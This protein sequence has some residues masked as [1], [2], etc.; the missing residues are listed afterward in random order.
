M[1]CYY[2]LEAWRSKDGGIT[3]ELA[4]ANPD[5]PVML[6]CGGCIGC[7]LDKSNEW[8]LRCVHEAQF[9]SDSCFV[10][11]T[12]D[13]D[14]LPHNES[15]I[16]AHICTFMKSLK[17]KL[18]REKKIKIRY[19]GGGEYGTNQQGVLNPYTGKVQL[20]RPHYHAIIFGWN[21]DDKVP[22]K[23]ESKKNCEGY[24]TYTSET[25][26]KVWNKGH[27]VLGDLTFKSARY[28]AGYI[29]KKVGGEMADQHYYKVLPRTGELVRVIPEF[30][31]MS[32]KPGIGYEWFKRYKDDCRKGYIYHDGHKIA[33]P[34]YYVQKLGEEDPSAANK[35]RKLRLEH[36]AGIED[37]ERHFDRLRTKETLLNRKSE[38][39]Q[40]RENIR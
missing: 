36:Q 5:Y 34:E 29:M 7:R 38:L 30:S 31:T 1:A 24:W 27:C 21:P 14:H 10:T 37:V 15:L 13:N 32:L 23:Y 19:F 16:K 26:N 8:A 22:Y 35:L 17:Q 18:W 33:I 20:G 9:H 25:L 11:L 12:Y 4:N 28:T 40:K 3:F 6:P 2:P 39:A